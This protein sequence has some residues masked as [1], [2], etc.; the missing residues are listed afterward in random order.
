MVYINDCMIIINNK[1]ENRVFIYDRKNRV[2]YNINSDMFDILERIKN[3]LFTKDSLLKE[4]GQE[5]IEQLF[6]L[7]ILTEKEQKNI[8][9]VKR[10][11]KYNNVRIFAELTNKCNLKCKHCYGGFACSNNKFLSI[12]KLK[13]VIDN[14]S[15][16]GVYQFDITGGE[17][18]LYPDLEELLKYLYNSGMMVRIFTNLTL[19]SPK[20]KNLILKYGVKDIVTSLD[21]CVKEDHDEFRG[22][23]GAFDKTINAIKELQK[24]DVDISLNTMIGNHNKNHISELVD[25]ISSLNVRSVMDVIVPEGR[26]SILN[27]D[28]HE[29]ARIIKKIYDSNNENLDKDSLSIGCGVCNRF[30]Y[31]KSDENIYLCPSLIY[32]EYKLG[33]I[34]SFDT[35]KIWKSM[36]EKFKNISCGDKTDKCKKCTGGCRARALKLNGNICCKDDVYCILNGVEK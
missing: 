33:N 8:N 11:T 36:T 18:T 2:E 3:N 34:N 12:E 22:Q 24:D 7:Q 35:E 20:L 16:C 9:N 31:L 4:Y 26:A 30:I 25:F 15:N 27:E 10:L 6:D 17:P 14:A 13:K 28:I 23:E 29:S 5:L 1:F 19:F 21:S 32:D